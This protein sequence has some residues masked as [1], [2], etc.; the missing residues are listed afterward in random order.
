MD[1][2][3][4]TGR[5]WNILK[6]Y[7]MKN[8]TIEDI[9][10]KFS[11]I[12][13]V[14]KTNK[15]SIY[16][17][18]DK[19]PEY[20]TGYSESV[21]QYERIS[22]HA[23]EGVFPY[24]LFKHRSPNQT[25]QEFS[26]IRNNYK[27]ITLPVFLDYQNTRGRA[28]H[29]SNWSIAYELEDKKFENQYFRDYVE[30]E[31]P[32]YG[33]LLSFVTDIM[34]TLKAKDPNGVLVVKPDEYEY[35]EG[36]DEDGNPILIL[37][38]QALLNPTVY[39]Y[40]CKQVVYFK[41]DDLAI[42][43]IDEKSSVEYAGRNQM[44]GNIYEAHTSDAIYKIIQVGKYVEYTFEIKVELVHNWGQM[45]VNR[46][47]G[48][49]K[50]INNKLFYESPFIYAVDN[51][52]LAVL[53]SA[54][55]VASKAKCVYPVRVM[56][57]SECDFT[58]GNNRCND[59]KIY[60]DSNGVN[61]EKTCPKCNGSGL[62][63]RISPMGDLLWNPDGLADS[64]GKGMEIMKY[65][66]PETHTLDFLKLEI[67]DNIQRAK[68]ILHLTTTESQSNGKD[69]TAT[70]DA[71]ENKALMAFVKSIAE[72][73]FDLYEWLLDAIGW[74][75][76]GTDYKKPNI[77]RPITF[78]FTTE[79]DYLELLKYARESGASPVVIRQILIKYITSIYFTNKNSSDAFTLLMSVDTIMEKS[80]EEVDM[81]LAQG[82]NS[83][84][85]VIIHNSGINIIQD[86]FTLNPGFFELSFE[87]QK[88][89]VIAEAKKM[90]E[91]TKVDPV[92]DILN[93]T[94][95]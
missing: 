39:Y 34:P 45:L 57:G 26:W 10:K 52:D 66:S 50:L 5:K 65:V 36:K 71:I 7:D 35:K 20:Y 24:E 46:L 82:I 31:L 54:N 94:A 74:V 23:D 16:G 64:Q 53:D 37:D 95:P 9:Q 40:P 13:E 81:L 22:I 70:F 56:V 43:E 72:Q 73:E 30:N 91:E 78:D 12:I 42:I 32:E 89:Q 76:Y 14:L 18:D 38:D 60:Y 11:P 90:A 77:I 19:L 33:S 15:K 6:Q 93:N 55:L 67:S 84:Y 87:V 44:M 79:K 28:W 51:L 49:P 63:N 2:I 47:G 48:I 29:N 69:T 88:E 80:S 1:V 4:L 3:L 75:R 41:E 25:D 62:K 92:N 27:Q 21:R 8:Y 61:T 58:E 17:K 83:K 68:N 86:L 59:G 85:Q